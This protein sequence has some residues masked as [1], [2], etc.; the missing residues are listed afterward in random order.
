M[1][2]S[3][4]TLLSIMPDLMHDYVVE[5]SCVEALLLL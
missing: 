3:P 1:T 5:V 2:Y 4:R